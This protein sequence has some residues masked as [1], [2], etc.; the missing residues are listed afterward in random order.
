MSFYI[1]GIGTS[2]P[3]GSISRNDAASLA[4]EL[5]AFSAAEARLVR[6]L[7]RRSGVERRHSVLLHPATE[8]NVRQ[9]FFA[10]DEAD[11]ADNGPTTRARMEVY[12]A[13]AADLA[14]RAVRQALD[15]AGVSSAEI[16]HLITVSCSGF[17]APGVDIALIDRTGFFP[18]VSRT[19]VGFMGCH[20]AFN[21]LRVADGF[22]AADPEACVLICAVELCS[23]HFQYRASREQHVANALF[24]D[25]AAAIVAQARTKGADRWQF[26]AGGST[27]FPDSTQAMTWR[28]GDNGFVMTLSARVPELI[29]AFLKPWLE[30]WV[31][32]NNARRFD[33][34]SWA[35]HP[36]G[37][38]IVD[39]VQ[40]ALGLEEPATHASR[41]VLAD[42]GNMSSPTILF[43]LKN[44]M[45]NNAPRP[46]VA[47]GFGPGLAAEAM[48]FR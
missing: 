32:R 45:E 7:Y 42:Y 39:A 41:R 37:P 35:I 9:S 25:G 27:I 34:A 8:G 26:V 20:G 36:G 19:H 23:L 44:L 31:S 1:A 29:E 21:A 17:A 3:A 6:A 5:S 43:I 38:R 24:A 40:K 18:G 10:R 30:A 2:L 22:I 12:H 48:L 11:P 47:L 28:I 46:C 16:T 15:H 13:A 14:A 4:C 33:I